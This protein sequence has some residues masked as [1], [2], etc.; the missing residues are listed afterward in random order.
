MPHED[1]ERIVSLHYEALYRFALSLARNEADASDLTQQTFYVWATK[2]QQ[3]RDGNKVKSWLF[4]TLHREFLDSRRRAVRFQHC[5]LDDAEPDL[6]SISPEVVNTLDGALAVALLA[7]VK[8]PYRA[9][10]TLFYLEDYSYREIADILN[11]PL[12]TVQSRIF[13]GMEQLQ[14]LILPSE[15]VALGL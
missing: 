8:E 15:G 3:L 1:F 5:E 4:T 7:H 11:L 13:R 6:P 9:A 10:L 14:E 12:G 2:G